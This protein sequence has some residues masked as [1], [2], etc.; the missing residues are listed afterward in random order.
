MDSA[1]EMGHVRKLQAQHMRMQEKTFTNWINNVFQHGRVGMK[2]QNLYTELGDGTQLLRLLELISGEALPPPSRGR[3]RVHFLEN[4]SRALAFLRAKVPIPLI[5]PENIVDGDQTHILGLIWVVILRFQISH[6]TLDREEFGAS[7]ALLSAKEA[8]LMWCQRKTASYASVHIAD[9]SRSW[10]DGLGFCALIHAHRPDLIDYSSLRPEHPLHNLDLAFRMA[11]RELGVAQLLDPEDVAAPQPDER[12]I[13]TYISLFYHLFSRLHQGQTVQKRLTKILLQVHEA[14]ELQT[15]YERLVADLLRWIAEQQVQ[16]EARDFPDSLPAMRQLLAAFASFRT[17]EKPPRLQQRG[18]TEALLFRLQTALRAQNRRPFLPPEGLSPAELSQRWAGLEQAEA[19]RSQA[20]QQRLLQLERLETLARRFQHKAALRESFLMDTEQVL[21]QAGALPASL[22]MVQ[23]A[24]QRLGMLEAGILPQEGRFQALAE[25]T[26]ILQQEQ[27]HSWVDVAHRQMEISQRWERLLQRLQGQR[28]QMASRQAVLSLLQ[29]VEAASHQLREL[30]VPASSTACGQQLAEVVE[31]LQRHDLLEAQ[32]SAQGARVSHLVHQTAE[33]DS[34]ED[35]SVAG[36]QAKAQ[37]LTQ[38]HQNLVSLIRAR[39]ALLEQALQHADFLSNCEEEESCL[40]E[41]RQLVESAAL[42]REL[43]QISAA[44]QKLKAVEAEIR[45]HQA[46]CADLVRR[47]R[48]L[49][50]RR[51]QTQPDPGELAEAVKGA[52][53]LLRARTAGLG[54]RLQAALLVKQYFAD[55]ADAASWLREQRPLLEGAS[56][57]QDQAGAEALMRRHRQLERALRAFAAEVQRLEEQA[58]AA[59]ARASLSGELPEG[60]SRVDGDATGRPQHET[61]IWAALGS[62]PSRPHVQ[63]LF[64]YQGLHFTSLPG[65]ALEL[66]HQTGPDTQELR[67]SESCPAKV[68]QVVPALSP[69]GEGPRNQG[70][71]ACWEASSHSGPWGPQ[72]VT[73]PVEPDPDFDPNTIL[74]TQDSLRQDYEGLQALAELR[75]AR[76]EEVVLLFAF[77][78]SC[79]ELQS[80]LE[81]QAVLFQILQPQADNLVA[82]QL[83]YENFLTALAVG[84]GRWAEVGSAAKQLK[85]KCPGDATKIQQLHEELSQRWG[86]LEALKEEKERQLVQITR[87]S[88]FLQ[89]CGSAQVQLRD[90][91]LRLE[92]LELGSP[93]GSHHVLPLAQQKLPVLEGTIHHL[94]RV[95]SEVEESGPEESR[96]LQEQVKMLQGLLKQ[97]QGQAAQQAQA[98]AQARARQSFLQES[99]Q[100]L[101]WAGSIRAQLHSKEVVADVASAQQLLAEHQDLLEDIRP[102]QERPQQLE[103][104]GQHLA[105]LDSLDS[106]EMTSVLRLLGQQGRELKLAWEQRQQRLQEGLELQRFGRK[107]D[108]FTAA[109]ANH[110]AFLRQDKLGE[111][112]GEAQSLLQQHREFELLLDTL[113]PGVEALQAHGERLA[114]SQHPAAP[115]VRERLQR[116]QTQWTRVQGRREQRRRQLLASLQLQEWKQDME[117]LMLWM[118]EKG[119]LVAGDPPREPSSLLRK[120]KWHEAAESELLATRG[121]VEDLQQVGRELLST[122][123]PAQGDVQAGLQALSSKW[124]VLTRQMAEHG[125]KLWQARQQEQLLGLLQG[126]KEKLEHLEGSLQSMEMGQ[127]L[128]SSRE[129]QKQLCQLEGKR[130]AL[131]SEVAAL[132]FQAHQAASSQTLLEETQK[133]LQ[134][135]ESLQ[136]RLA[137]RHQQLQASVEWYQFDHLSK[138]ELAWVAEHMPNASSPH[139]T[140]S[141]DGAQRLC[142]KHKE[143]QAEV[144]AHQGWVQRVLG[145]GQSLVASR[146]PQAQHITEQ[147]QKLEGRWAELEQ[148]CE[149]RA[150][151]LGQAV[152]LQQYFLDVS[153]LEG[154]LEEKWPLVS[155]QDPG[156]DKAATCSLIRKHQALQQELARYWS[157]MEELDERAQTLID[158]EAPEQPGVVQERLRGQLQAVQ[159]LAATRDRELEGTLKL[160]EFM[161]E[162]EDLQIWLASQKQVAGEGESLGEDYEHVLHLRTKFVKFRHQVEMGG[163]RVATCQQLAER[164]LEHGHSSAPKVHQRQR[165]LQAAWSELWEL[166]QARGHLLR[167]AE[168]TLRVH[169]DL[170]EALTQIQEKAASL[171]DD[172]A[173]DLGGVEAQLRR[174]EG[175]ECELTGTKRQ[176]QELLETAGM[177]QKLRPGPQA[178]V[179]QR[180]Q[181][182]LEQAWEALRLQVEQRRAQLERARLLGHFHAAVWHYASWA[183]GV[184]QE[185]QVEESSQDFSSAPLKLSI[186]QQLRAELKAQDELYQQAAQLGQQALLAAGAPTKEVQERLRALQDEREHVFWAWEQKQERLQAMHR[187]QLFLRECGRLDRILVAQ[188]VSLK[189]SVLGNSVEEVEQLIHKHE[190]FRKVLTAQE[191]KEMA[192]REQAKTLQGPRVQNALDAVLALRARVKELAGSR[193]HALHTSLLTAGFTRAVAQ[194]EDWLQE[195][196]QRLKEPIPPGDLK[197][198]SKHRQKHQA[199]EAEVRAHEEVITSLCKMGEALLAQSP[200]RA[201]EVSQKLRALQEHWE[202][203]RQAVALWSQDLEDQRDFLDFLWRVD[204]AEAWIQEKEVTVHVSDLGQDLEHCLQLSRHLRQFLGASVGVRG[205]PGESLAMASPHGRIRLRG[206]KERGLGPAGASGIDSALTTC[207]RR[208]RLCRA[209]FSSLKW[210]MVDGAHVRSIHDLSLQLKSRDPEEIKAI[211]QRRNQLTDRWNRFHGNLLQ[212]QWQLE[213]AL[214]IHTLSQELDIVTERIVEK[215]SLLQALGYGEDLESLERLL[216]R[217]EQLEQE[218]G[219]L[220]ARV[221][222]LEP[223]VSRLCQRSPGAARSL[224][225]KQREVMDG[226]RQ[227]QSRARKR[228]ELLGASRQAQKLQAMLQEL[229]AWARRLRE[230][231]DIGSTPSSPA[232]AQRL[233]EEHRQHKAELDSR[234]DSIGLARSTGQ[235]LLAAAHPSTPDICQALASLEQELGSLEGAWQERQLQLQ[236]ALELQLFLSSAEKI[237]SWLCSQ[238]A[239]LASGDLEDP[240]ADVETLLWKLKVLEQGLEAEAGPISKLE[241]AARSL[242]QAGHPGAQSALGRC[243]AVLLRKEA[244]LEQ[245][246][247]GRRQLEELRLQTFLQDSSEAAIWLREKTPGA[248]DEGWRDPATL[249]AQWQRQQNLQAELDSSAHHQQGLQ[250]EGQ[251]LLQGGH[252]ASETIRERLQE[253]R[254]LWDQL[255][256]KC[257]RKAAELQEAWE[258]LHLQRSLE[259]LESCLEP[260]E[261]ELQATLREQDLSGVA[262][263]LGAQGELEA[264]VDGQARQARALL[265]QAQAFAREGPCPTKD[266]EEQARRLL[267]RFE[268]LREPL[269]E[270]R[271]AL[272]AR[273]L[274]HQFFRDADEEMAWVQEKL[275]LAAAQDYGPSLDAVWHLQ[276]KHQNLESEI[277]SHEAL[278]WAVVGTG[279]KLVRA[280]HFAAR[281]VATRVQDLESAMGRLRAEVAR[282]RLRLQQALEAQQLLTELLEADSWLADRGCVLDSEDLGRSVEATQALLRRLEATRRDLEGFRTRLE[283]L[284]ERAV[285]LEG[286]Q[287]PESPKVLAQLQVVGEAHVGLLRRAEGRAQGLQEQLQLHHLEQEALLLDSWLAGKV[288]AAESQDYGQDLEGVKALEEK[289]DVF[290]K[291]VQSL[292]QAKMQALRELADSLEQGAP[293]RF[294]QIQAQKSRVEATWERLDGAIK[295]RTENLAATREAHSFEQAMA[296]LQGWMREKAALMEGRGPGHDL[297]AVQMLQQQHRRLERELVAVEEEAARLRVEAHRLGQLCPA[298]RE[299]LAKQLAEMQEAWAALEGK[300]QQRGRQLEQAAQGHAFLRRCRELLAWAQERQ[301]LVSSEELVGDV[302][303]AERL[304]GQVEELGQEIEKQCLRAQDVRQEGQQLVDNGHFMSPEVIEC[305][306]EL[307]GGLQQLQKAWALRRECCEDSWELQTLRQG[308]EQ[309]EAWLASR[310]GLLLDPNCG[311]SVSEV[312]LLLHRHQGLEKLLAAQEDKF[313]QLQK[314]TEMEQKLLQQL[315]AESWEPGRLGGRGSQWTPLQGRPARHQGPGAQQAETRAPQPG[316]PIGG[317]SLV[318]VQAARQ[319]APSGAG[320]VVVAKGA[321][322]TEGILEHKQQPLP[323][324]RQPS[325]CSWESCPGAFLGGSLNLLPA[326]RMATA[327]QT[328]A[329]TATLDL[330]G[331]HCNKSGDHHGRK[332]TFSLRLS[333]R[334]E[335]LLGAPPEGQAESWLRAPSSKTAQLSPEFKARPLGFPRES[336]ER[337]PSKAALP[338]F[339]HCPSPGAQPATAL[340]V[341]TSPTEGDGCVHKQALAALSAPSP[342]W[343]CRENSTRL[344]RPFPLRPGPGTGS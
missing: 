63:M 125:D 229:L 57:G 297:P 256:A 239:S 328:M 148:A 110:E 333:S 95:A 281:E 165:D 23:A 137:T 56:C 180:R 50:A 292:G 290:R 275:P 66:V 119:L 338:R 45:R 30:Q 327:A 203:L 7:A 195:G 126:A 277:S 54:E 192:L 344:P 118:E 93:E 142:R 133:C 207:T 129:L 162:A 303:G 160:H 274:L 325:L 107:V 51:P 44:L 234:M 210:D 15:Q 158:P 305:L 190:A 300:A 122:G 202:K 302:A 209:A 204:R 88:S 270:R 9:F 35:P 276:E 120:L 175:L 266:L 252:L 3:L 294:P 96:P 117:E 139:H 343:S 174:H 257:Q 213:G 316:V 178:D 191:E 156:R 89:E 173:Q 196:A 77:Y 182:A 60:W 128:R 267:Q 225:R 140:K 314:L 315:K 176:V 227:L 86:Q 6:I 282:R 47:G 211:S 19:A 4:N 154:W 36:L 212:Y 251:R 236:Q 121:H 194:A 198:K 319:Q 318:M 17:Q 312:E 307:E 115:E 39:R 215:G 76:L 197:D 97:V 33:L 80:W 336:T 246:G 102:Q 258:A 116:A 55:A 164:L 263:L 295:V 90:L 92:G 113:G 321:P 268:N 342:G 127:D 72:E 264:A 306:Q 230:E 326:E 104:Q 13:M 231:M 94:Q 11:E 289:F 309:A 21:G 38:L 109:C 100:L 134:R 151:S 69:P 341:P 214:E 144:K 200:P 320:T 75:R 248:L 285:L 189:T 152:A 238:E 168:V 237:E 25:I 111:D 254:E 1:Y 247:A 52:W 255:Q 105:A 172:V 12:S 340:P 249:Q 205:P 41:H 135:C 171:P 59:A 170:S 24:A 271:A 280:R 331:A 243:Q 253:L 224:G 159:E 141:L 123:P 29:E 153:E 226:W 130:Q 337:L 187:E 206:G 286:R 78:S 233:L 70:A 240:L 138:M 273:G 183:A 103:A 87:V 150:Q 228:R 288:I 27:Y 272:E 330:A 188:E 221:E 334:P 40:R 43:S 16:L 136:G 58:R 157:F 208:G 166:S 155:S 131:A 283:R 259:E 145:S 241:A 261:A 323:G 296:A 163:Q 339:D 20:L 79:G 220:Q 242:H 301:V 279:H 61:Q 99:R 73:L 32:V 217:H 299:G 186:H 235:Q 218:M 143:L 169:R 147:C 83:K 179:V 81:D 201:G 71:Q 42:A 287:N 310:E 91:I 68:P 223:E 85:Q 232:E 31:L 146:H 82:S 48:D 74:Q 332:H 298:A 67:D 269:R 335:I 329:S 8:L 181:Q 34:S 5:G 278:T 132:S 101:L 106:Q 317:L 65:R 199:F 124:E 98:Q 112:T 108:G 313:H 10:S 222:H 46:V 193:G 244:L 291:E 2:I 177:V 262:Q 53:Q 26:D 167:D 216:W 18:A 84:K 308:L 184:Q 161:R 311:H 304:L 185:L 265:S 245:A 37:G 28:K 284:Q 322:S 260:V 293:G 219:L 114:Q 149:A 14:E 49:G 250:T 64:C 324:G 62:Q 22:A